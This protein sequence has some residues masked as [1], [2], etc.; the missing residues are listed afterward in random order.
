[1]ISDF[2]SFIGT[3]KNIRN[4]EIQETVTAL[5]LK[6]FLVSFSICKS[7]Y[8]PIYKVGAHYRLTH[9][10]LLLYY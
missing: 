5:Y 6:P 9:I 10:L 1:M 7:I 2:L 3:L 4:S 8:G